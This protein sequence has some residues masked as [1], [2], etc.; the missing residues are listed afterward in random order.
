MNIKYIYKLS[1]RYP[2]IPVIRENVL[3]KFIDRKRNIG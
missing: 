3:N 2:E 1:V